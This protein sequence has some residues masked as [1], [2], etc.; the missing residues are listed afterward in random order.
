MEDPSQWRL[1]TETGIPYRVYEGSPYGR[2][3]E[4]TGEITERL[5]IRASDLIQFKD[6]AFSQ[7]EI[8]GSSWSWIP[9]RV[10]PNTNYMTLNMSFEPF[11]KNIP[12]DPWNCE[13]E[14]GS[15]IPAGPNTY[16]EYMLVTITYS[17]SQNKE[18][19]SDAVEFG[20]HVTGEFMVTKMAFPMKWA[21]NLAG[22]GVIYAYKDI[23]DVSSIPRLVPGIEWNVKFRPVPW[24]A[25]SQIVGRARELLGCVNSDASLPLF[26]ATDRETVMFVGLSLQSVFTWRRNTPFAW[27]TMKFL[28]RRII[29]DTVDYSVL[30]YKDDVL[31][32]NHF[33]NPEVGCFMRVVRR[34]L[35]WTVLG[36]LSP[37]L[38]QWEN[39]Y[40]VA[41]LSPLFNVRN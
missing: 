13:G 34:K 23:T 6:D 21:I 30:S 27:I 40:K 7:Y 39:I 15:P 9:G 16:A 36:T 22:P 20:A 33:W 26:G 38:F 29:D 41:P 25:V 2:F 24:S 17:S 18:W 14:A 32:W 4:I 5:I 35:M 8:S 28:E 3:D 10:Y 37:M 11:P 31:G 1:Q 12:A 19:T